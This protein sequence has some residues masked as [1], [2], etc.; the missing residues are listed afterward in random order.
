MT[1]I[2]KLLKLTYRMILENKLNFLE[3]NQ[4]A[5]T[6]V[7]DAEFVKKQKSF[8][9]DGL[10]MTPVFQVRDYFPDKHAQ[11]HRFIT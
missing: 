3:F 9:D 4:L 5:Y 11:D 7:S 1:Q 2:H 6:A 10:T 8:D